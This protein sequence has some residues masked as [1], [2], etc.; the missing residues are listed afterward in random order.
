MMIDLGQ[1]LASPDL[2]HSVE[3]QILGHFQKVFA[4]LSLSEV[5]AVGLTVCPGLQSF[6]FLE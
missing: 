2:E 5:V 1:V 6:L 3:N 4:S